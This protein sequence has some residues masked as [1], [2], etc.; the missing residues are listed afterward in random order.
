MLLRAAGSSSDFIRSASITVK[1]SA[2]SVP[3]DHC[4]ENN[5]S[6][7]DVE[8]VLTIGSHSASAESSDLKLRQNSH[9]SLHR[10][11]G[12]ERDTY[13]PLFRLAEDSEPQLCSYYQTGGIYA[14][15]DHTGHAR[16]I[17][18][19]V[20]KAIA[21][22]ELKAVAVDAAVQGQ[23]IGQQMVKAVLAELRCAGVRRVIVGTG[24]C[25]IGQL[26]FY[27]KLGFRLWL[28]ERDFFSADRGYPSGITENRIPLRD[29]VWM[30][31]QL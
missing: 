2:N 14:Y 1:T 11:S 29:M 10:P 9:A 28:I 12:K 7:H 23:G 24:S 5:A 31:M 30:D 8:N 17:V 26:A 18:L 4:Q 15:R 16:G 13:L 6:H 3:L 21:E 20:P 19:V 25:G 22:V 27:Q